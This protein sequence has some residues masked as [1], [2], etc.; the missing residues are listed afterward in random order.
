[1][2][3]INVQQGSVEWHQ[4]RAASFTASE[5]PAMMGA[6]KYQSRADLL[7]QKAIGVT[8]EVSPAQQRI[9]DKGHAAE[10]KARPIA[11]RIIGEDLYPATANSD[12]HEKLLASFDGIT[13]MEDICWE[14][15]LWNESLATAV[16]AGELE[17]HYYWQLEQQLLVSGAEKALFMCSDG[18]E[19][20][21]AYVW[22]VPVSGR[23]EELLAGWAQFE[24]DLGNYEHK[25]VKPEVVGK[26]IQDLP[27][28]LV[29]ISGEVR[30]TNLPEFESQ[31]LAFI[32]SINTELSTDQDFAD[33]EKAIKFCDRT[34][35]ELKSVKERALAQTASIEELFK[36]IDRISAETRKKRLDLNKLVQAK[37]EQIRLDIAQA[38]R[39]ALSA[40]TAD[41]ERTIEGKFNEQ[42][43]V[44]LPAIQ[45][46]FVAAMKGKKTI[47]SLQSAVD[48]ALAK[49][50]IEAT[51]WSEK[52]TG[53]LLVI[54][55]TGADYQFLFHDYRQLILL[56]QAHLKAEVENRITAHKAAEEKRIKEEAERLQRAAQAKADAE[57]Q[58]KQKVEPAAE[59]NVVTEPRFKAPTGR[60]LEVAET[61][62][63]SMEIAEW[64]GRNSISGPAV[65]ELEDLL[66]GF[67]INATDL[68][69]AA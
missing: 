48:D 27:A 23:A 62:N 28:L 32:G 33:A 65:A 36:T 4:A 39:N 59:S 3:L 41:I 50:K 53:N 11:E 54:S 12:E 31:A 35:K 60:Q 10:D 42:Y 9:F 37:K 15:K 64:A 1:M 43:P 21:M 56:D 49:A 63:L 7:K 20:K 61:K 68:N 34:E 13:M 52:I 46:D 55:E 66:A 18:T 5:A 19:E 44:T 67:G 69:I 45:V 8:P 57:A 29:E 6:S 38:A 40:L 51:Q 47:I 14:H 2:K 26:D 24:E 17:P 58:A 30:N 16:L 22:Y 25:E